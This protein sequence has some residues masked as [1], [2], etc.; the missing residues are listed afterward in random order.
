MPT[1]AELVLLARAGDREALAAILDRYGDRLYDLFS[2]V[3]RDPDAAFDAMV[4]TFVLAALEL[5]RLRKPHR[6]E[7]WLFALAREQLM[8]RRI[9]IGVDHH[10]EFDGPT[11]AAAA[12]GAGAIV[13]EAVSWLPPRDRILLELHARQP[14]DD[15][16]LASALGVSRPHAAGLVRDLDERVERLMSAL[17]VAR[18]SR[19]GCPPLERL[20]ASEDQQ[21][22]DAWLRQVALHVDVCRTCLLWREDQPS[23]V[24]LVKRV[25]IEPAPP[26]LRDE[27][28]DRIDLLWSE[29]GPPN[30]SAS[31]ETGKPMALAPTGGVDETAEFSVEEVAG[32]V[33]DATAPIEEAEPVAASGA[34]GAEPEE[35]VASGDGEE[36]VE[37]EYD[38]IDDLDE[39][40]EIE[41]LLPPPPRLRRNGF[42]RGGMYPKR[43]RRVVLGLMLLAGLITAAIVLNWRGFGPGNDRVF[44]NDARAAARSA[45]ATTTT[46]PPTTAPVPTTAPPPDVRGPVVFN[47]TTVHG[48]IGPN[49][50][51][52]TAIASVVDPEE[53][54][55]ASVELQF[56]DAAGTETRRPMTRTGGRYEAAIGPYEVDGNITWSVAGADS[57]G[58]VGSRISD[59]AVAASP[60]C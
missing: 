6:V 22:P 54:R 16:A 28:L 46:A 30:W 4:D 11:G 59:Q 33:D 24:Q 52:T 39:I 57:L 42:P 32:Q 49:Q 53:D 34:P 48:C 43:R 23:A 3:L 27:I 58:N 15:A 31:V 7:P 1:D 10:A 5:Y 40:E 41:S 21:H 13:W 26:E 47:L 12:V 20:I 25:P 29:L 37:G 8:T 35:V 2:S 56:V 51:S 19:P 60:A 9:P 36:Y 50:T 14:L 55:P 38:E 18:L 17:L 44:A 45:A